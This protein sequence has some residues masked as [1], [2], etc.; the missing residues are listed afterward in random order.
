[1]ENLKNLH[2]SALKH[3]FVG[4]SNT[5][6]LNSE[7]GPTIL[8]EG[9]GIYVWDEEGNRYLDGISGMYFRNIGYGREEVAKEIYEQLSNVSMNMYS[10][11]TEA[12]ILLAQKIAD[13]TP[14][15]LTKT[16]FSSGGSEA[17]ETSI[18]MAQAFHNRQGNKG[19]YK[20]ISRKG[21]YH[22]G[23]LG[24]M[25]LGSHPFLPRN[26]YQPVPLNVLHAPN[27]NPY[28][29]EE[30]GARNEE[31]CG[32]KAAKAIEDL[33]IFHNPDSISAVIGEPIAQPLGGVVPPSNYWPM[34]KNIC[35]K[36]GVI[37]I[38]DEI[39]T[40]FGR[41]GEWFGSDL[42]KV[43]P[44]IMSVA[45]GMTS[46]YF[47][48]G[49]SIASS[50]VSRLFNG[51]KEESFKHMFTY[52]GHPGGSAAALKNIEIIENENLVFNAKI[53]GEQLKTGLNELK[54]K[55]KIIGDVRG[56]GLLQGLEFVKDRKTKE[57]FSSKAK[58]GKRIT[59]GLRKRGVW[60]KVSD[61]I[62]PIAP[63]LT[64]SSSEINDLLLV[65]EET[66]VDVQKELFS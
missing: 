66:L 55:L 63:P 61:Y 53:R 52:S 1:M 58:L 36:Y 51:G 24:T 38:F 16:F 59:D 39:I 28:R 62:L 37:L 47:P 6:D 34:V 11:V 15:N 20:I 30:I 56:I 2:E 54:G 13:L 46:G 43:T 17:N 19:K 33:I 4:M 10:A 40:G 14:G 64:I 26:E 32:E 42:V 12:T 49:A 60:I 31:E 65:I 35:E 25:W 29:F 57:L 48:L 3:L 23:T 22:G 9:K 50:Q 41:L 18:K 21:S 8:K 27:P 44:D 45:K 7:G 5:D